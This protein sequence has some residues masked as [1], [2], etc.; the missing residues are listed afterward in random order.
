MDLW[1]YLFLIGMFLVAIVA[2][3]WMTL[4][5]IQR[6][7][8]RRKAEQAGEAPTRPARQVRTISTRPAEEP[9]DS[10]NQ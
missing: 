3:V 9:G 8:A 6:G 5:T 1:M 4:W 10:G 7:E 2:T